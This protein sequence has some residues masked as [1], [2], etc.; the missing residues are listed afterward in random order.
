MQ[1][2][3]VGEWLFHCH[4]NDHNMAGM[5]EFYT[6]L[7]TADPSCAVNT[8]KQ[9]DGLNKARTEFINQAVQRCR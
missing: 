2:D 9:P 5:T 3:E 8:L 7:D 4:V 1:P 6:V